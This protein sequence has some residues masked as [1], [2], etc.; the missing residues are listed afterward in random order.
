LE[1]LI[2]T[3]N[4]HKVR[5]I[6]AILAGLPIS[7]RTTSDWPNATEVSEPGD[8]YEVN[9]TIKAVIWSE[10]TGLWTLSDDSGLE[11]DALNG[12]PGVRSA[13]YAAYGQSP[14]KKLLGELD[15]V[16]AE[17]RGAR[18]VCVACLSSPDGRA[19]KTRGELHG[20]IGH[21]ERGV[22]GF[23]FDPVFVPR[24]HAGRHLAELPEDAKNAISHRALALGKMRPHLEKL[25]AGGLP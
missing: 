6:S 5:E 10:R 17:K 9:A 18:F 12:R 7:W 21:E 14:I 22:G 24:D 1:L 3:G 16:P 15:G 20:R 2:A 23:G 4:R 19:I 8:T 13:R 11:V 25:C